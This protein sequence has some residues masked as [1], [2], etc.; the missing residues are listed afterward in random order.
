[1]VTT[2][3]LTPEP[4]LRR[5]TGNADTAPAG[6]SSSSP[7]VTTEGTGASSATSTTRVGPPSSSTPA[8]DETTSTAAQQNERPVYE[9]KVYYNGKMYEGTGRLPRDA[10]FTPSYINTYTVN[11]AIAF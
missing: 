11:S 2:D 8:V 9:G 3:T 5:R 10:P 1:M 6:P 4:T 7:V